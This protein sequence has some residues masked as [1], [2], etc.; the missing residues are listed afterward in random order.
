MKYSRKSLFKFFKFLSW[1][2]L[3]WLIPASG[4]EVGILKDTSRG[5]WS[6]YISFSSTTT[7]ISPCI[8]KNISEDE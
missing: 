4:R 2:S 5:V 3:S 7:K 8:T 1:L 6:A